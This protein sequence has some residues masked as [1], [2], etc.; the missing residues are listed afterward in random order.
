MIRSQVQ[1]PHHWSYIHT[2]DGND[3]VQSAGMGFSK[4]ANVDVESERLAMEVDGGGDTGQGDEEQPDVS[5]P[6]L[7]LTVSSASPVFL[8]FLASLL[9]LIW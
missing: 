9:V 8:V 3:H 4:S 2:A 6:G 7:Y 1:C 5:D